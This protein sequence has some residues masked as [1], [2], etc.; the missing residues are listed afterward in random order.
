MSMPRS[1][2]SSSLNAR[3]IL[4]QQIKEEQQTKRS[5]LGKLREIK[6]YLSFDLVPQLWS[7]AVENEAFFDKVD[8]LV[9]EIG[10]KA[11]EIVDHSASEPWFEGDYSHPHPLKLWRDLESA[12]EGAVTVVVDETAH[13][14]LTRR[15]TL[16][17]WLSGHR[18]DMC[19]AKFLMKTLDPE[20]FM[21]LSMMNGQIRSINGSKHTAENFYP[22]DHV[23]KALWR[24]VR[25]E[26]ADASWL[27]TDQMSALV[28]HLEEEEFWGGNFS[29]FI[30]RESKQN[31]PT[32]LQK[33]FVHRSRAT[34]QPN[35]PISN[36][37]AAF[38]I[39]RS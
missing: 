18:H 1:S 6:Q 23:E 7:V 4:A 25:K 38:R 13:P 15:M 10:S 11:N 12:F 35:C 19:A 22:C 5:I 36:V 39:S 24:L 34:F 9:S 26:E 16:N 21:I 27:I 2:R 17:E 20:L 29:W 30:K 32:S 8:E 3:S 28:S 31:L 37:I 14:V 33:L